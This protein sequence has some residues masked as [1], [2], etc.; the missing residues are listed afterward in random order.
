MSILSPTLKEFSYYIQK[1]PLYLRKSHGFVQHFKIWYDVLTGSSDI[2][3][4]VP[5]ADTILALLNIFDDDYLD[6]LAQ[7]SDDEY[8]SL[9]DTNGFDLLDTDGETLLSTSDDSSVFVSDILDKI[10]ALFGV[11]RSFSVTYA[12]SLT[13]ITKELTLNNS[14][15]L[16][17][18]KSQIIKHYFDGSY[19]QSR[20]Y[21]DSVG[22][23]LFVTTD[24][25]SI[26]TANLYLLKS[27][28]YDE[29]SENI[30][31]MF[32][33]G[34]LTI[35]SMGI[36]YYQIVVDLESALWWDS[37][38]FAQSWDNGEWLI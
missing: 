18:I 9:L 25:S 16:I 11:K 35:E 15:F 28:N 27:A 21:Y 26:A 2:S 19:A 4:I 12:D 23:R 3:G 1:L 7:L 5:C 29:Y 36:Q 22:L 30:E 13:T 31:A 14:D 32:L 6:K 38:I 8:E 37:D 10:G 20:D 33:A 34:L 17:L 24:M